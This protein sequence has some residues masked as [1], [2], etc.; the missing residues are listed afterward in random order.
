[1]TFFQQNEP[2]CLFVQLGKELSWLDKKTG[3][4]W[5]YLLAIPPMPQ[6]SRMIEKLAKNLLCPV[7]DKLHFDHLT[8][9][10]NNLS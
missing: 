1:M 4:K 10:Y 2:K 8:Q 9:L 7:F 6:N 5:L 3:K